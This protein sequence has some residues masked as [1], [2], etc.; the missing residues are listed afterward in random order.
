MKINLNSEAQ[1][2]MKAGPKENVILP[3]LTL[4]Y[5]FLLHSFDRFHPW[6]L[7]VL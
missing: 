4:N 7:A 3:L 6:F 2:K 1:W 5:L